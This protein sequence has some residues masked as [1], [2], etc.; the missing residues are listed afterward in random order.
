[1]L[2]E[3]DSYNL[4]DAGLEFLHATSGGSHGQLLA[5]MKNVY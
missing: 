3:T 5:D 2:Q 1:M 4:L